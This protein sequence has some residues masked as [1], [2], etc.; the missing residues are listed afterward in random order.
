[1]MNK[2]NCKLECVVRTMCFNNN[3]ID[4][5]LTPTDNTQGYCQSYAH[6]ITIHHICQTCQSMGRKVGI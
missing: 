4:C 2:T 3:P 1:M 5:L 6:Q